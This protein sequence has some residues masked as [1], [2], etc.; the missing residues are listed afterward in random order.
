MT[1]DE[2]QEQPGGWGVLGAGALGLTVALRLAQRGQRGTVLEREPDPGGLAAGFP[3]PGVADTYL[4]KFYHHLFRSDRDAIA[5]IEELGLGSRLLW[6]RPVTASLVGGRRWPLDSPAAVLRFAPLSLVDRLRLGATIAYLR[7][8]RS[9]HRLEDRTAASW[10][11]RTMGT[12]TYELLWQP[13]FRGKFGAFAEQIAL[14]WFWSRVHLRSASLGYVQGG[15]QHVYN[16]L[17]RELRDRGGKVLLGREVDRIGT[18]PGGAVEV[19]SHRVAPA[20]AANTTGGT[21]GTPTRHSFGRVV[22][23]LPTRITLGLA[24]QFPA[25]FARQFDW[26]HAYGAH[27][28]ILALDRPFMPPVY[29]LNINDPGYPFIAVVE[30]TNLMPASDYGGQRLLYVGNYLPMD[31]ELFVQSDETTLTQFYL[32]LQRINPAF[33]PG[34]VQARWVWKAPFAQPIVTTEHRQHIPPHESPLPGLYLA[35]MFQVYPQ[36][37]GQNYSI[38]LANRL[39]DRLPRLAVPGPQ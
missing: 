19:V 20:G 21:L 38:R 22:S 9:H 29:W 16:A 34:W 3:V 4:E 31:H 36:D 15:F 6:P 27:C 26:G 10:L 23:T 37:R 18:Q 33:D 14:P 25:S 39:V 32:H 13:L 30:H 7:L 5:L 2:R 35:N 24:P 1:D 28:A 8:E 17:V 12:R 11:R